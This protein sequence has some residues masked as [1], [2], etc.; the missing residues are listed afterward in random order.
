MP[1]EEHIHWLKW[2][3]NRMPDTEKANEA[4][5]VLEELLTDLKKLR[6]E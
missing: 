6:E 1:S 5:A 2:A 4:E 3:I